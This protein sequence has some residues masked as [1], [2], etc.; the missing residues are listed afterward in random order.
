MGACEEQTEFELRAQF[1]T[2]VYGTFNVIRAT[3]PMLRERSTARFINLTSTSIVLYGFK[4]LMISW[5]YRGSW[6]RS[7]LRY[8][9]G[10]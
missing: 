10:Y 4:G 5:D 1:E 8:E 9:V 2:N 3:L 6:I 7:L